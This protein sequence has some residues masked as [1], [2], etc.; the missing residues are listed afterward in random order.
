MVSPNQ[1]LAS[2]KRC[3]VREVMGIGGTTQTSPSNVALTTRWSK[4]G[5][6]KVNLD[7]GPVRGALFSDPLI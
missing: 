2:R 7:H 6:S 3:S 1:E 4:A 5:S